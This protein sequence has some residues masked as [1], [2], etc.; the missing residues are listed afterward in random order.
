M[1]LPITFAEAVLGANVSVPTLD[2]SVTLKIPAGTPSGKTFRIRGRGA[3]KPRRGGHG[4]LL[5]TVKVDVPGHLSKE[6]RELVKQLHD[7]EQVPPG[8][9][10]MLREVVT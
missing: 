9:A 8:R 3:P 7:I 6:E 2:G 5:V 4:D 1:E 10:D